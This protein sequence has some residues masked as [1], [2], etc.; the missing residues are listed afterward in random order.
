MLPVLEWKIGQ[1]RLV[2][3]GFGKVSSK[4]VCLQSRYIASIYICI[5][6]GLVHEERG[7]ENLEEI[8]QA[9]I[10]M[11]WQLHIVSMTP[12]HSKHITYV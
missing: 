3:L 11:D 10:V 6:F 1:L 12:I 2:I 4:K 7:K 5:R 9:Y 8:L